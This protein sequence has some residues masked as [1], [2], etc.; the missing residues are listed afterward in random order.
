MPPWEKGGKEKEAC[1]YA[2]C[3]IFS[4][5]LIFLFVMQ[6]IK[7]SKQR[8]KRWTRNAKSKGSIDSLR[9]VVFLFVVVCLSAREGSTDPFSPLPRKM[10]KHMQECHRLCL[11]E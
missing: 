5:I 10:R 11:C 4:P 8:A 2:A 9:L 3:C 6:K 7:K 1:W